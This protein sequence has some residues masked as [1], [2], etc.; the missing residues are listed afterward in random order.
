MSSKKIKPVGITHVGI[1]VRDLDK[2]IE[3]YSEL[4]DFDNIE[5]MEV[6][7]EA[8]RVAMLKIGD[9]EIEL[10]CPT[11]DEGA[12]AKFIRERGE[13]IHHIAIRVL[14]V[15][16]AIQSA[17]TMGLRVIDEGPRN[18]A[19]GA[20]AAF[21]HPKSLCGVLLEFYDR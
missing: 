14:D 4:F 19:R 10:L 15:A 18:G 13:G 2:A 16:G 1:A 6:G 8:V 17:K 21:V 3:T 20:K 9:S 11:G 7:G 5:R 12:I